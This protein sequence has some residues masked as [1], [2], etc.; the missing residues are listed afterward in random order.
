VFLAQ[1]VMR[2]PG[3]SA[4]PGVSSEG[5]GSRRV[6]SIN[7]KL[8]IA[9]IYLLSLLPLN[10]ARWL[11]RS[12][13]RL[14]ALRG[15][16][17]LSVT[18]INIDLCFPTLSQVERRKLAAQSYLALGETVAESGA[19]WIWP[20]D[21]L[22]SKVTS[23]HNEQ[24][25]TNGV[26]A[27]RGVIAIIP[28]LGNWE[29]VGLYLAQLHKTTSL[30]EPP[31]DPGLDRLIYKGRIRNGANLVATNKKGVAALL[32]SLRA[33]HIVAVL[34]DQLPREATSGANALFFNNSAMT[35]SLVSRLLVKTNASAVFIGAIRCR[36]GFEIVM[37]EPSADLYSTDLDLSLAALNAGV[38]KMILLAPEQY[39]WEYKRFRPV[40]RSG[41]N[42]YLN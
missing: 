6:K 14:M 29:V 17:G 26:G 3:R 35:M 2:R 12:C 31:K 41:T 23:V 4:N 27:E 42:P 24:L 33:G 11:G 7:S 25:L 10:A 16:R 39:S 20:A 5:L 36:D 38:E 1:Q 9:L 19:S 21:K 28:H 32:K 30:Y 8:G 40:P 22:L 18:R 13:A 37:H 15:P 34:P